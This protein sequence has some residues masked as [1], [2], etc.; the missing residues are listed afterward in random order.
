MTGQGFE[1]LVDQET[2]KNVLARFCD[3]Q[4]IMS[5]DSDQSAAPRGSSDVTLASV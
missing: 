5:W 3:G 1:I 4:F 2:R